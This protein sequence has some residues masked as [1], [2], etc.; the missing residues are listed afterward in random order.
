MNPRVWSDSDYFQQ[1]EI[2][3]NLSFLSINYSKIQEFLSL[4][5]CI[6]NRIVDNVSTK[7]QYPYLGGKIQIPN[8]QLKTKTV[9]LNFIVA[10]I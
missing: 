1:F 2:F 8:E 10:T 6:Y 9:K 3:P 4:L 7:N 5:T